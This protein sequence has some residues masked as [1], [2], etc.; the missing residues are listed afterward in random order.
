[1]NIYS[2]TDE[3]YFFFSLSFFR[4]K[5]SIFL[6]SPTYFF[7]LMGK[8]LGLKPNTPIIFVP[9]LSLHE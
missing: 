1:M 7:N 6:A 8:N 9:L 2:Q 3:K 5:E 4:K